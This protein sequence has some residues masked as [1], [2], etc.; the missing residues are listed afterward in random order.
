MGLPCVAGSTPLGYPWNPLSTFKP[1]MYGYDMSQ[2]LNINHTIG[3]SM[4]C[5][6]Y[7]MK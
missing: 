1:G 6:K 2:V 4:K 3:L 5:K 7:K